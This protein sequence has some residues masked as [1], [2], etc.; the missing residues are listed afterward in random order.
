[1]VGQLRAAAVSVA[2]LAEVG[3]VG[4]GLLLLRRWWWLEA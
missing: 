2:G 1:M 3:G 4:Q